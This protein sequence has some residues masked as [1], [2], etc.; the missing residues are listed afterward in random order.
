MK[1]RPL[2]PK[3][4]RRVLNNK[5]LTAECRPNFSK[6]FLG[7]IVLQLG[8]ILNNI[9]FNRILRS[10]SPPIFEKYNKSEKVRFFIVRWHL[11]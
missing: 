8:F 4:N 3:T 10:R 1:L 6:R 2:D 7:R 5:A 9:F 11:K